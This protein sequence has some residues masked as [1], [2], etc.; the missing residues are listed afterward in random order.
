MQPCQPRTSQRASFLQ[1]PQAGL[2]SNLKPEKEIKLNV[3]AVT[4]DSAAAGTLATLSPGT[5]SEVWAVCLLQQLRLHPSQAGGQRGGGLQEREV[6][7][8]PRAT[9]PDLI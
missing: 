9:A 6:K 5:P 3:R 2:T 1:L 4:G 8:H 7:L